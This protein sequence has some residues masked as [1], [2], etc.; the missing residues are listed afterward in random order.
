MQKKWRQ[1][2]GQPKPGERVRK[3]E[4]ECG[5]NKGANREGEMN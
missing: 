1:G 2:K 3:Q 4:G 5:E